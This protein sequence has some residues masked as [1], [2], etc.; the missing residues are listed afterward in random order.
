MPTRF[1]DH[2]KSH[3]QQCFVIATDFKTNIDVARRWF[4]GVCSDGW[5]GRW[6]EHFECFTCFSQRRG[7]VLRAF[8]PGCL[9]RCSSL[10]SIV[11]QPGLDNVSFRAVCGN[12]H[13]VK[14]QFMFGQR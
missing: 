14:F 12:T 9:C 6:F 8:D 10:R 11:F 1:L 5:G 3:V 4:D 7:Q 2:I 13:L